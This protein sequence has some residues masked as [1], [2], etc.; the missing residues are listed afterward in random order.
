MPCRV[1][2]DRHVMVESSDKTWS[3]LK[4]GMA[5]HSSILALRTPNF[6]GV[7]RVIIALCALLYDLQVIFNIKQVHLENWHI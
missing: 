5:N 2:Q 7:R 6:P 4:E 3:L 1:T